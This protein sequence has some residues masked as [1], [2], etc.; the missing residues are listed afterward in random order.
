[1]MRFFCSKT[2]IYNRIDIPAIH[3]RKAL[4]I[5]RL[6]PCI[7]LGIE[8]VIEG[9]PSAWGI[10]VAPILAGAGIV[11]A[12][13]PG[14]LLGWVLVA[15]VVV[16][17]AAAWLARAPGEAVPV[18]INAPEQPAASEEI[19]RRAMALLDSAERQLNTGETEA[20]RVSY[21]EAGTLFGNLGDAQG[22]AI[23]AFGLGKLAHFTGQSGDARKW[24]AE[25]LDLYEH[26][27]EATDRARVLV[28]LG[29]LEKDTFHWDEARNYYRGARAQW[30]LAPQPKSDP[31]V[32]LRID[33]LAAMPEGEVRARADLEQADKIYDNIGDLAGRG[34]I[35]MLLGHLDANLDR[36]DAARA[37]FAE[38]RTFYSAAAAPKKEAESNLAMARAEIRRGFNVEAKEALGHAARLYEEIGAGP[39]PSLALAWGDLER[40]QGRYAEARAHY[41]EAMETLQAL[42]DL[43]EAD[44]WAAIGA[45]ESF[46]G[47]RAE[48]DRDFE[49]AIQMFER[50]DFRTG[51]ARSM[52]A[53]GDHAVATGRP[54][55]AR[56]NFTHAAPLFAADGDA[57]GEARA[58]F[59]LGLLD[60]RE[61]AAGAARATLTQVRGQFQEAGAPFGEALAAA[62]LGDLEQAAGN[63]VAARRAYQR[64]SR[65][66]AQIEAPVAEANR[67]LGL[68]PV[69]RIET[70]MGEDEDY[71]RG[72]VP[73]ELDGPTIDEIIAQNI[74]AYPNHNAEARALVADLAARLAAAL[75]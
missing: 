40:L 14:P 62:A 8:I 61:Q 27:G 52:L 71:G 15:G 9:L 26:D 12:R 39:P 1:M 41:F 74:A 19:R 24:Y 5:L 70:R 38:A 60:A 53:Y 13:M 3:Y 56:A 11:S 34:D 23:A 55:L 43:G 48:A 25:A 59:G 73:A 10:D 35:A 31:H 44:A 36:F 16:A 28:A 32:L 21:R 64:A 46:L 65:T 37:R 30:A 49:V 68:P 69:Q 20:A 47:N 50:M 57:L 63:A 22:Q 6:A 18:A 58:R 2:S 17:A 4:D 29:D 33:S 7:I 72:V 54:S 66:L 67:Y 45:V 75:P 42:A 51:R